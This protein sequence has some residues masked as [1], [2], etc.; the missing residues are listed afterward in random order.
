M[1]FEFETEE[2]RK[3][4]NQG[5]QQAL[6]ILFEGDD[7]I[8]NAVTRRNSEG[9]VVPPINPS[10]YVNL[11]I[12]DDQGNV[13]EKG[14]LIY[15]LKEAGIFDDDLKL[16][17]K[18]RAYTI[19]QEELLQ[20][21]RLLEEF[22]IARQDGL[23]GMG[24]DVDLENAVSEIGR[25]VSDATTGLGGQIKNESLSL[26]DFMT[27][28][29]FFTPKERAEIYAES[30]AFETAYREGIRKDTRLLASMAEVGGEK[31]ASFFDPAQNE[32]QEKIERLSLASARQDLE[33]TKYNNQKLKLG[34]LADELDLVIGPD[35]INS[36]YGYKTPSAQ[37]QIQ[38]ARDTIGSSQVEKI[39]REG[40]AF[41]EIAGPTNLPTIGVGSVVGA[42]K[43]VTT[44]AA[45]S[46]AKHA[47]RYQ[48]IASGIART[49]TQIMDAASK[50]SRSSRYSAMATGA[51][52]SL[53]S[54]FDEVGDQL[55]LRRAREADELATRQSSMAAKFGDDIA[56]LS[57]E[58]A[59]LTQEAEKI[60]VKVPASFSKAL[61][62]TQEVGGRILKEG[63]FKLAGA[64]L[65]AIGGTLT[66][67]DDVF[68]DLAERSGIGSVYNV[69]NSGVG[70]AGIA[71]TSALLGPI[72]AYVAGAKTV[73]N[74]GKILERLGNTFRVVGKEMIRARGQV[75]FWRRV[76]NA[77]NIS[78]AHRAL[79]HGLDHLKV[80]N[81]YQGAKNFTKGT[82]ATYPIDL[83]F[84]YLAAG[85]EFNQSVMN[86]A[87]AE[88]GVLGGS[89]AMLGGIF[90][91]SKK[92]F[93]ELAAGDELNY[94]SELNPEQKSV[95]FSASPTMR[96]AISTFSAVFPNSDIRV[97]RNGGTGGYHDQ[98][99]IVIDLDSK[100]PLKELLGHE[101]MH[102]ISYVNQMDQGI[103]ALLIGDG[104]FGGILRSPDG[105]LDEGFRKFS[106]EYKRR[107]AVQY[108]RNG[109]QAPSLS[110]DYLANEYFADVVGRRL[111]ESAVSGELGQAAARTTIERKIA[112]FIDGILPKAPI[113]KNFHA[114][115]GGQFDASGNMVMGSGLLSEGLKDLPEI[116]NMMKNMVTTAAGYSMGQFKPIGITDKSS[117]VSVPINKN[118]KPMIDLVGPV[119]FKGEYVNGVWQNALDKNGD[120][121][122]I[123]SKVDSERASSGFVV[124]D[125]VAQNSDG[126]E[127]NGQMRLKDG[128]VSE[129]WMPQYAI[130]AL[131]DAGI[132]NP[133]QIRIIE[134]INNAIK[135]FD[136]KRFSIIYHAAL[137]K[138]KKGKIRYE[139]LEATI[140]DVVPMGFKVS[141]KGNILVSL[142]DVRRLN[143]N[144]DRL[145]DSKRGLS[146]Y[147]RNRNAFM[148]DLGAVMDIW[149]SGGSTDSYFQSKYPSDWQQRK[150]FVNLAFGLSSRAQT[151]IDPNTG[152][153]PNPLF[154]EDN[155][156][157]NSVFA[158]YRADRMSRAT[159]MSGEKPN[160][161]VQYAS[162]VG[163]L[164]PNGLPTLDENGNPVAQKF[165]D[166]SIT[167]P[168][169]EQF[170]SNA[171]SEINKIKNAAIGVEDGATFNLDGT[172]FT[173]GA[174]IVP[175]ESINL[176][177]SEL[178]SD[179]IVEFMN[180]N[181]DMIPAGAPVK[182]GIYKFQNEDKVSIDMN[183]LVD[184]KHRDVALE[185]GKKLGQESLFDTTNLENV[186][187]GATGDNPV[188]MTPEQFKTAA[189]YLSRGE[190]P[191]I[192]FDQQDSGQRFM[193]EG[194]DEDKF[195]SQL[196]RVITDKV[197]SR[198]TPQQIMA[199]IDPT[200]GSGVKA[201]EIKWS[202]IEQALA[203]LE[204]DGKVSKEDLL[205]YLRNEG[206]VRFEEVTVVGDTAKYAQYQLPGGENY[207]EVVLA[208]PGEDQYNNI[209]QELY[210][211]NYSEL[212][213][214]NFENSQKAAQAR[215]AVK[216]EARKRG[217]E[218]S[219]VYTSP[220]FPNIPNYVAHMRTNERVDAGGR[221]GLFVEEFQSDRHQEGRKR[222]YREDI[223]SAQKRA[224]EVEKRLRD[225]LLETGLSPDQAYSQN[226]EYSALRDELDLLPDPQ[227]PAG[228]VADA[229]FRTTWPL[230]LF[231]RAL[232]D[233]V[234]SGKE[235]VGWTTGETQAERFDLNRQ[236]DSVEIFKRDTGNWGVIATKNGNRVLSREATTTQLPDLIGKELAEKAVSEGGGTYKGDDLKVGG[237]G[238]KG[239]YDNM[240]PKEIGKYVK[241]FGG[242][243]EKSQIDTEK[244]RQGAGAEPTIS[245]IADFAGIS[246]DEYL[247]LNPSDQQR[248]NQEARV[249]FKPPTESTPIW[250]VSITPEMRQ[251]AQGQMRFMPE[252]AVV[253]ERFTG[254]KE[255]IDRRGKYVEPPGFFKRFNID[256]YE[257][258][259]KFFDAS[260]GEDLTG[261]QYATGSIDVSTG[262]PRL[263]V[264]NISDVTKSGAKFKTNLFKQSAGWK[265]T[266]ENPP[267]TSTIVSVEG[268][269][270]HVYSLKANFESGVELAR[271]SEKK[272]EPRLRPTAYGEL[273]LGNPV[274]EI[275][276]RGKLHPVYDSI[277]VTAKAQGSR[278]MP[279]KIDADYMKA[280]ESGDVEAQ[281]R[282]VDAAAKEAGY[283]MS[284]RQSKPVMSEKGDVVLFVDDS[285]S[286]TSYGN[287]NFTVKGL[288]EVPTYVKDFAK[289]YY[290]EDGQ[291]EPDDILESAQAWDDRQFVSDLWQEFEDRFISDGIVGFKTPDGGVV[292]DRFTAL[293]NGQIKSADPIT[294]DDSGNIIPPSKR[295]DLGS[296][297]I[298]Y[299]PEGVS[300]LPENVI[301]PDDI[302][303]GKI[304]AKGKNSIL[305][306]GDSIGT[307]RYLPEGFVEKFALTDEDKKYLKGK[308]GFAF[309]SDWA[310]SERKYVTKNG[311]EVDVMYGGIGY[312]FIPEMQGKAAWASTRGGKIVGTVAKKIESTDGIGLI[313][314]GGRQ[315]SASS[316]AFSIAFTEELLDAVDNGTDATLLNDAIKKAFVDYNDFLKSKGKKKQLK[317]AESITDW[318]REF[319]GLTFEDRA[320]L[321]KRIG[322]DKNKKSLGIL[323]WNDVLK[324]YNIQNKDYTPGQIVGIVE[325][326][327]R[328]AISAEEAGV[329]YHPSYEAVFPGRQIGVLKQKLMIGDFF[330]DFFSKE[331]TKPASYTRKVQTKMP[332]FTVGEGSS[333]LP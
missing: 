280:V 299:M 174:L 113:V 161:P 313:V 105:T 118:D 244:P 211:K 13:T 316:R 79:A 44:R 178:S 131:K 47:N 234:D 293:S 146:L 191:P 71:G 121:I 108:E 208:M 100:N 284:H 279:E 239:F 193:P 331:G 228:A 224:A 85:A 235:W 250:K 88:S 81:L 188:K 107:M 61:T 106:D 1:A 32:E 184:P 281:Q 3:R 43:S 269:G 294:R 213:T 60:S 140:R 117:R 260:N 95:F 73:L 83:G 158:T 36:L 143:A 130:K 199:T 154:L 63:P 197:P 24:A 227:P 12:T 322:S 8:K 194:V 14:L 264:D 80:A 286:N 103:A 201:E 147:G 4:F 96:R 240:L 55:L 93:R 247:N 41:A 20:D 145:I 56:S 64:T 164:M 307:F 17:T 324:K 51:A 89:S 168:S 245:E 268:Q 237:S 289:E 189:E 187:T 75:P 185:F 209:A 252:V 115:I 144:V 169:V 129:G 333:Y 302:E 49:Q 138:S 46:A 236:V 323:S 242:K 163:N 304:V 70:V 192:E 72:P 198:A 325:F 271:Y 173:E 102:H 86:Q 207:R 204:K 249:S 196:D 99:K 246:V 267:S 320:A 309:V 18:G 37:Q 287:H 195:Y 308:S 40:Q 212:T 53:R 180:A 136:G 42:A 76:A 298:R 328:A 319:G 91:G 155:I 139:S 226:K 172:K 220:H 314:L 9:V 216:R 266:S 276:I 312:P 148:Q 109:Q 165:Y 110:L 6:G 241:P 300:M 272:S 50:A 296:S 82:L 124:A 306:E 200:R 114:R 90:K 291:T 111:F 160:M 97:V 116:R 221:P 48:E 270:K 263:F 253:P 243:V 101:V 251:L 67:V 57:D 142:M 231:K 202:G 261:K 33:Y 2:E 175:G 274:G 326:S 159:N 157:G 205:N 152:R 15:N 52:T 265:W 285:A 58:L 21:K 297:D 29:V 223:G 256:S 5:T 329:P 23:Y 305:K 222:G 11:G 218:T 128:E 229:P 288:P 179:K 254:S 318:S 104:E 45:L 215:I 295:F 277:G 156:K 112:G 238:M 59:S 275:S 16:T 34:E 255:D 77:P 69:L 123:S 186:K 282:I 214:R 68:A 151:M 332:I 35:F 162:V 166:K 273:K 150:N 7:S 259:G 132:L 248:L 181:K 26:F 122:P 54:Q 153:I 135:K 257:R 84:E 126:T 283:E 182:F 120:P 233:A 219:S 28:G 25:M 303:V 78:S 203:S 62:S 225:I 22:E 262:K 167:I 30:V 39:S 92:R 278:L 137:G 171:S 321:V 327:K 301:V 38:F 127:A 141:K 94:L 19:P 206:R 31:L 310:D 149:N 183:I 66:R 98:G 311:R 74:S 27:N 190:M 232:R 258:G 315:S 65:E 87:L 290:G 125:A 10:E 176:T 177:Q 119:L 210:G 317:V 170:D 230:Q 217:F 330:K 292:F 134:N 133:A